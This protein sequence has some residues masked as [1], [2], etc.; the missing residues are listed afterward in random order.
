MN[1]P[2]FV[3]FFKNWWFIHGLQTTLEHWGQWTV[4]T[5]DICKELHYLS[6][7]RY[8]CRSAPLQHCYHG[9]SSNQMEDD[10]GDNILDSPSNKESR[11]YSE[12]EEDFF[13]SPEPRQLN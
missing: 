7:L 10:F 11:R 6:D 12:I 5:F 3:S 13:A 9:S 1:K 2:I 8:N 4:P